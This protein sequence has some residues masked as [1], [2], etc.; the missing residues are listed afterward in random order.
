MQSA[1]I[2]DNGSTIE[3]WMPED[4]YFA[5]NK[6]VVRMSVSRLKRAFVHIGCGDAQYDAVGVAMDG[7]V[8]MDVSSYIQSIFDDVKLSID[9]YDG[10]WK[11]NFARTV[12]FHFGYELEDGTTRK[13]IYQHDIVYIWGALKVGET[14]NE[15]KEYTVWEGYPFSFPLYLKLGGFIQITKE[16]QI[17]T[18]ISIRTSGMLALCFTTLSVGT[19][20][21]IMISAQTVRT[22]FSSAFNY[23]FESS[24]LGSAGVKLCSV[25]V[26]GY[27]EGIYL[28][29]IDRHGGWR[30]WLFE[31]GDESR[32]VT[33]D[34]EFIRSVLSTTSTISDELGYSGRRKGYEVERTIE[35]CAPL[36]DSDTYDMLS[37][38]SSSPVVD[39]WLGDDYNNWMSVTIKEGTYQKTRAVLQDFIC[40]M[41]LNDIAVQRL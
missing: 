25:D 26:R 41:V 36:V 21:F 10:A 33:T 34:G 17:V 12:S 23:T 29:W 4:L 13:G 31:R 40:N 9:S 19:Y 18:G 39:L 1:S 7:S 16:G 32:A 22:T 28:R 3:L 6:S 35:L 14:F 24:S 30:Y 27:R 8:T 20:T 37:D 38:I 2:S 5:F 15:C 11:T